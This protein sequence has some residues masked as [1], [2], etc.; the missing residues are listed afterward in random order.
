MTLT[1]HQQQERMTG[2]GGSDASVVAGL[3]PYKTPMELF[4]EKTG[5]MI[6]DDLSD[7]ER[8][9]FG[10]VLED[11]VAQ[12][13]ARRL[14]KRVKRSNVML[15]HPKHQFMTGNIDRIVIG[16][17]KV[18]ECKTAD[19]RMSGHW[20]DSG[21]D[22]VPEAYLCQVQHYMAVTGYQQADLAVLIGGNDFRVYHIQ[23]SNELIEYL[24][25]IETDFWKLVETNTPP[26]PMSPDDVIL[27]W[28]R[29][30]GGDI[31]ATAEIE[32]HAQELKAVKA[33][34]KQLEGRKSEIET[35]L[36]GFIQDKTTLVGLDGKPLATWKAQTS[37]RF[38]QSEF[39]AAHA[40]LFEAF[41]QESSSRVFRLK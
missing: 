11:V 8:V 28:P 3:N 17:K 30:T 38:N 16:E 2:V 36:K 40:K 23:R 13:Y 10:N 33:Q 34:I 4:F 41:K 22:E 37:M 26:D 31:E 25:H 29:D 32:Q 24:I 21:S 27:R 9:H 39:K 7:N 6:P 12:E 14:G 5:A 35:E 20:G 15:R 19:A 18:L 1:A